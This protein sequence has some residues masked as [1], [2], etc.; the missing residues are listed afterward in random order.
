MKNAFDGLVSRLG[1]AEKRISEL[2]D[3]NRNFQN[4]KAKSKKTK[5]NK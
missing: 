5:T 4:G 1:M 3:V 2:E